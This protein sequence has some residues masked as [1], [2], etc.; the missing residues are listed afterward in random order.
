MMCVFDGSCG[1][2][3][4]KLRLCIVEK[5]DLAVKCR[6]H[7]DLRVSNSALLMCAMTVP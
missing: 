6:E 5:S 7:R 2:V 3:Q 1:K 4:K